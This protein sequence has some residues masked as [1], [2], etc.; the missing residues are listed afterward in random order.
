MGREIADLGS[1][2][3]SI[4]SAKAREL[5]R[6]DSRIKP[7]TA[8]PVAPLIGHGGRGEDEAPC[9]GRNR[10]TTPR[11][12]RKIFYCCSFQSVRADGGLVGQQLN[13][14]RGQHGDLQREFLNPQRGQLDRFHS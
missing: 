3:G 2:R 1:L 4:S 9:S 13:C 8:E 11:V 14:I 12:F 6:T 5:W 7:G 10:L